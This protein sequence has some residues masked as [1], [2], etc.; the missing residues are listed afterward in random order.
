M[1]GSAQRKVRGLFAEFVLLAVRHNASED[2]VKP[3][4]YG[5]RGL[6]RACTSVNA[7]CSGLNSPFTGPLAIATFRLL[8]YGEETAEFNSEL[9]QKTRPLQQFV[10][11]DVGEEAGTQVHCFEPRE[12]GRERNTSDSDAE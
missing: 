12:G 8:L 2:Q 10:E 7:L 4:P 3:P 5:S 11:D 9:A 6:I 1:L